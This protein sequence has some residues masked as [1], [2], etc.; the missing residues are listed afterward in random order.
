MSGSF[1]AGSLLE[2][3]G[4]QWLLTRA[5]PFDACTVLSLEG[6]DRDNV[7]ERMDVIDPFDRARPLSSRSLDR[8][9]RR[10]V[11]AHALAAIHASKPADGLWTAAA[12]R[13]DLHAYQLEPALAA[14]SG[15]PRMLLADA[16]GLG[17]TIQAGLVLS[18]LHHR[19]WIERALIVCPAGLRATWQRELR[20][21]FSIEAAILDQQSIAERIAVLP[22]GIN[23]W[24]TENIAIVS[25]DF[26]KREEVMAA[27]DAVP[28]DLLIAD[29]AHHL[30]PGS[31]RGAAVA[32]LAARAAW[33]V[34][35]SATPHSGDRTA[36]EY[37]T[38]LGRHADQL[39]IFR[40]S[41]R[42]AGFS[43]ARRTQ[44]LK[45]RPNAEERALFDAIERYSRAIWCGRGQIDHAARLVAIT[46][47]R[48]ASSSAAAISRT[49][50][51]RLA[52][53]GSTLIVTEQP[54]L[55]WEDIDEA[56]GDDAA[57]ILAVHGLDNLD[58]E[59]SL[60]QQ[61]IAFAAQCR[62]SSKMNR[63]TRLLSRISEPA[64]IF[65]EYRDTLEAITTA[66]PRSYRIAS[67]H[68]ALPLDARHA[69]VDRFNSGDLDI[70]VATDAAGEG[71]NLHHR[72]R[73]VID[74]EL[75]WTPLRLEQRIGRVDRIGQSR[76]VH[77]IRLFH[78]GTIEQDVLDRLALR[79]D[80]AHH[81]LHHA[82]NERDVAAAVFTGNNVIGGDISPL[83]GAT[84][85][86]AASEKA[87]LEDQ[88]R[89]SGRHVLRGRC[90]TAP[91]RSRDRRLIVVCR[92][93][94]RNAHGVLVG[95]RVLAYK[96]R[97]RERPRRDRDWRAAIDQS[98]ARPGFRPLDGGLEGRAAIHRRVNAIRTHLAR[99]ERREYQRSLFDGRA[100]ATQTGREQIAV[101]L[102]A[103]LRRIEAATAIDSL[104]T[105]IQVVAAWPE[106]R[107]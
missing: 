90:W 89:R 62:S 107:P 63:L 75:P 2:I 84:I 61:L 95:N 100:D 39:L 33:C 55:P 94:C 70:L 8:R 49:L 52:L 88:R 11:I 35:A 86:A 16:V 14:L 19:G 80:R 40:R 7:M 73:L 12:A 67:L 101:R 13:M 31:D 9:R 99:A 85:A 45:V 72:C 29:E 105:Q 102:D 96:V 64:I 60:L 43:D 54:H 76:C 83:R 81:D 87:R 71:L 91:R 36:F 103:A 104:P 50:Q 46:I 56:D 23:P 32:R 17:K 30:T 28:I 3:R 25:I 78:A 6:R 21:R 10:V 20:D 68:G 57:T 15:A 26:I 27:L 48:R 1:E 82:I 22:V 41:R 47:A 69:V 53:I 97:L 93:T 58:D 5:Q 4:Q 106:R 37:L 74:F 34:L 77:A 59:R 38:D 92:E 44:F 51:R 66:L 42:D 79:R 24:A 65:T 98:A 18:E